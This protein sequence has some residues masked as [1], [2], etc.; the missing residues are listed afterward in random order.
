MTRRHLLEILTAVVVQTIL[1][2]CAGAAELTHGP[3]I[4]HTTGTTARVWVRADGSCQLRVRAVPK[5]NGKAILADGIRLVESDNF[6]GSVVLKNLS[7]STTF[8]HPRRIATEF[9]S[10]IR[11][12]VHPFCR[13]SRLSPWRSTA[14]S[15][16]SASVTR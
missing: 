6:C 10:I 4:G 1:A 3:M 14:V 13:N 12:N 11:S 5:A 9:C 15:Y 2:T 7:P 16:E 8:L